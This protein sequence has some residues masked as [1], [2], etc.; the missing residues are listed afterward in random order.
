MDAG[1]RRAQYR[2]RCAQICQ[3]RRHQGKVLSISLAR[4]PTSH[5]QAGQGFLRR[6]H[7]WPI[8]LADDA[9][10]QQPTNR[11]RQADDTTSLA[12]RPPQARQQSDGTP[13]RVLRLHH[14]R[15]QTAHLRRNAGIRDRKRALDKRHRLAP[16]SRGR[17]V[18]WHATLAHVGGCSSAE[19][20]ADRAC[21]PC[22]SRNNT[23]VV[24]RDHAVFGAAAANAPRL[25]L[26]L[27]PCYQDPVERRLGGAR[28]YTG[29]AAYGL[30]GCTGAA[31]RWRASCR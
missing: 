1:P 20:P 21:A 19:Q 5:F 28:A 17:S 27:V 9:Q 25:P 16:S 31:P 13:A 26:A 2:R 12:Y 3:F 23:C 15:Q 8:L 29:V 6:I 24:V 4:A 30:S 11:C 22:S 10:H 14:A 7:R 18:A